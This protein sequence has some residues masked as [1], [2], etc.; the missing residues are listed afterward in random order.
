MDDNFEEGNDK[1]YSGM[2]IFVLS[3]MDKKWNGGGL[4]F[5]VLWGIEH[6]LWEHINHMRDEYL[7]TTAQYILDNNVRRFKIRNPVMNW[8]KN[9]LRFENFNTSY[10]ETLWFSYGQKTRR[11]LHK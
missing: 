4:N 7:K 10:F 9:C 2:S 1:A 3:I 5:K 11:T 6:S 8:K